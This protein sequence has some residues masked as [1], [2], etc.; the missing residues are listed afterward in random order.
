M[1]FLVCWIFVVK[2][3]SRIKIV[4]IQKD[5]REREKIQ[6]LNELS[7]VIRNPRRVQIQQNTYNCAWEFELKIL[8]I[9]ISL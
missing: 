1:E 2:F 6:Q 5:E 7:F 8:N 4:I 9:K 3:G